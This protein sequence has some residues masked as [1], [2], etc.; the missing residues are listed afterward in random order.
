M[1]RARCCNPPP[2]PSTGRFVDSQTKKEKKRIFPMPGKRWWIKGSTPSP[3][4]WRQRRR[5]PAV[6]RRLRA[7]HNFEVYS[8]TLVP[9]L[10]LWC[11]RL[12]CC[13]YQSPGWDDGL[14]TTTRV[15]IYRIGTRFY[16][17][18]GCHCFSTEIITPQNALPICTVLFRGHLTI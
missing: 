5:R 12:L 15:R 10:R 18:S 6:S 8:S 2:S 14:Y 17:V 1:S 13:V 7:A 16:C 3:L 4:H 9:P 11:E